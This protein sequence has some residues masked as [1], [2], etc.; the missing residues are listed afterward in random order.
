MADMLNHPSMEHRG[1]GTWSDYHFD[2]DTQTYK[3]FIYIPY[4]KGE[5]VSSTKNSAL[6]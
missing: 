2:R 4:K 6:D 5:E 1:L 3:V